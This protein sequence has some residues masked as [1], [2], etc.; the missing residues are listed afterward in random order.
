MTH[1]HLG[2]SIILY[3]WMNPA[4]PTDQSRVI[5][6]DKETFLDTSLAIVRGAHMVEQVKQY[7]GGY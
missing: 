4:Y 1:H 2:I 7:A 5:T 6:L 3:K